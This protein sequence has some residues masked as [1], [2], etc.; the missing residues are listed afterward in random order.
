[1][2]QNGHEVRK[3]SF[4]HRLWLDLKRNKAVYFMLA[5]VLA[6]F[7]VFC[8]LPMGGLVMAFQNYKIKLGFLRSKWVGFDNF[9][10]FFGSIY[11]SRLL[12]NT[13]MIGIKDIL[14]TIPCTVIFALMLNAVQNSLF[15]KSVQTVTYLPYF[16]SM[17]VA[18]G[19]IMD[20]TR[21]GSAI[22]NLVGVFSGKSESLLNNAGYFQ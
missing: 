9:K 11:F 12:T 17:V 1:M 4:G 14:W 10:R 8:Y 2:T 18:C 16:I 13:L 20:F 6:Y 21:E 5:I 15:K 19:L 7:I 3:R 22:S